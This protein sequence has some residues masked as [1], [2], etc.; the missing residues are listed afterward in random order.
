MDAAL[1]DLLTLTDQLTSLIWSM[2][3]DALAGPTP[4]AEWTARD[5]IEH[6]VGTTNKFADTVAGRA[7][8][9]T[10]DTALSGEP[11]DAFEAAAA[12]LRAAY[13]HPAEGATPDWQCAELSVHTWD[14]ASALGYDTAGLDQAP[15]ERGLAFMRANLSEEV[16]GEHFGPEQE[17]PEG[18]DAYTR[19]AAFAGRAVDR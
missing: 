1:R 2:E 5:L 18:A 11:A 7:A 9:W 16:R 15:A 12:R 8:D 13:E 14:L 6:I 19:A 4:C 3:P 10:A 17:P